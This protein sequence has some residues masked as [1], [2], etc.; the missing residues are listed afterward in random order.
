MPDL[1]DHNNDIDDHIDDEIATY[2]DLDNPKSFFL[3]AGAGSGKTRTLVN[4]L[5]N[6]LLAKYSKRLGLEGRKIAV[7]TYTNAACDEI[8]RRTDFHPLVHVSTIHSFAWMLIKGFND[9]IRE[10][11]K[12]SLN[13][14]I[15][16][17]EEKQA[18]GRASKASVDRA[19]KIISKTE[20]LE[21]LQSIKSF[22]YNPNGNQFGKDSLNHSEV[23]KIS[24]DFLMSKPLM[25]KI[26]ISQFPVLLIDES[27]DTNKGLVEAFFHIH[28]SFMKK[29]SIGFIGD[30]MQRIY[31]DGKEGLGLELDDSWE[32]PIKKMN[33]RSSKRV[34]NLINKIRLDADDKQQI[35]RTD[36]KDGLVRLFI[37][38]SNHLNKA[39]LETEIQTKMSAITTDENWSNPN[40]VKF[41]T[42]E[43][44]MA[45]S[46]LGFSQM[47]EP[48]RKEKKYV[49]G[50][51]DGTLP[52]VRFFSELILSLA[53]AFK[54]NDQFMVTRIVREK[55][56]LLSSKLLRRKKENQKII[57]ESVNNSVKKLSGLWDNN[58]DPS[59]LDI[60]KVIHETKLF[61]I[62]RGLMPIAKREETPEWLDEL[63]KEINDGESD[64]EEVSPLQ[65]LDDFLVTP[66]SQIRPY[67]AYVNSESR[68]DTHQGVK[69]LEFPKVM[70][71][72]DDLDARGFLFS[73]EKLFG[74]KDKTPAD[75]KNE[76]DGK[77]TG[78]DRTRRLLYVTCS[79]AEESLSLVVYTDAPKIL[80]NT[81][82]EKEWFEDH[83]IILM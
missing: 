10:W 68:F 42:I 73:Y 35:P 30:V 15:A 72:I 76:N 50:L 17:L 32:K 26:L 43:H 21:S 57:L 33:H 36:A 22:T 40:C 4:V 5:K 53:D 75:I 12:T 27:Q 29:I 3:F 38:N 82:L 25:Q 79:R 24:S 14:E 8:I 44:H 69:G 1:P 70:V 28:S 39:K 81:V 65:V 58:N 71:I 34:V 51:L 46:R 59:F 19:N 2:L 52:E 83:E 23:I 64:E 80:K 61:A 60:L 31:A 56:P 18:K 6:H 11:L 9:D 55:S 49:T 41:L 54:K 37:A 74:V 47:F 77:E 20:R 7:I 78:I 67:K 13:N 66:F 48:L 45:A 62:P 16:E 63:L